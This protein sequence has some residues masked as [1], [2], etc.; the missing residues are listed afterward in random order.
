MTMYPYTFYYILVNYSKP[1][2]YHYI[3]L[4]YKALRHPC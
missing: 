1:L 2:I 4:V 3:K